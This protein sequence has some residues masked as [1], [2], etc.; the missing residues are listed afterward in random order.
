VSTMKMILVYLVFLGGLP[1]IQSLQCYI[2]NSVTEE[3]DEV[4]HKGD[5]TT[6]AEGKD[7]ACFLTRI[8]FGT[9]GDKHNATI[10][11]G[12]SE[13]SDESEFGCRTGAVGHHDFAECICAGDGCNADFKTAAG[14]PLKC[15]SC[16]SLASPDGCS[17]ESSG[18]M[19]ECPIEKMKG[20][21]IS[22]V[23][24]NG[25]S[26]AFE[27]GCTGLTI[28]EEYTCQ[29]MIHDGHE[30]HFCNCHGEGCN[31]NWETA[32]GNIPDLTTT[33]TGGSGQTTSIPSSASKSANCLLSSL[34]TILF[35][36]SLY[37]KSKIVSNCYIVN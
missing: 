3:C 32:G 26:K 20:C 30:L 31:L 19:V 10:S 34:F 25:E 33:T 12:C 15:Y 7:K 35:L 14:P 28:E 6:C 2:C 29:D 11:R 27:R 16:N 21:F 22:N 18:E 1:A 37:L 13:L 24:T 17:T 9:G 36:H 8:T 4:E 5:L 23:F